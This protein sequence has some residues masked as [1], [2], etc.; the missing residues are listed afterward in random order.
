MQ[1]LP[2]CNST[3]GNLYFFMLENAPLS[4]GNNNMNILSGTKMLNELV[5]YIPTT[6]SPFLMPRFFNA[7]A[8][9]V[10]FFFS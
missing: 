9:S 7:E 6:L 10:T 8:N 3:L 2:K 4:M 1:T 5:P